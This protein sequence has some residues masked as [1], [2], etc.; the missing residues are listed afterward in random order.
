MAISLID[1][2]YNKTTKNTVREFICDTN[3]DLP[4]LPKC[5]PGSHALSVASG[6]KY[7]VNASGYWVLL[8]G[9]IIGDLLEGNGR[10]FH[11]VVPTVLVFKSPEPFAE[12][13][14][15]RINN[16]VVDPSNY[17]IEEGS[18]IVKLS[19]DYLK[20][21]DAG[22]Y[23]IVILSKNNMVTGKFTVTFTELN[24]YGI[25]PICG[26]DFNRTITFQNGNVGNAEMPASVSGIVGEEIPFPTIP[27]LSNYYF[28]G[29]YLDYACTKL[30]EETAFN[31]DLTLYAKWVS[32][33]SDQI[34]I[35]SLNADDSNSTIETGKIKTAIKEANNPDIVCLQKV[36]SNWLNH[37]ITNYTAPHSTQQS[38]NYLIYSKTDKLERIAGGVTDYCSYVVLKR[39]ADGAL[40][41]VINAYFDNSLNTDETT[42]QAQLDAMW[43]RIDG[44]WK[45]PD[46]GL[47]PI[48]ITGSIGAAPADSNVYQGLIKDSLFFDTSAITKLSLS[49]ASAATGDY[50]FASY[51]LQDSV[52]TYDLLTNTGNHYAL[53]VNI[54]TPNVCPH[55]LA[56]TEAVA[57]TCETAGNKEY[58]T[59]TIGGKVYEDENAVVET[60][61]EDC[62]IPAL[63]HTEVIDEAIPPTDT[64]TGLTE[65]KHCSICGK[66]LVE[67]EIIPAIETT[68]L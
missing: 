27:K 8:G 45:N 38:Q 32:N 19:I 49:E 12:F 63:G 57:A 10:E 37:N 35:M 9:G 66:V 6:N 7:I 28:A 39:K 17:T 51:H 21:F 47:M 54:A 67:Q 14:E 26:E 61:V 56:K 65:G 34:T 15:V 48:M 25:C 22:S 40:F 29:W 3:A 13:Q 31:E 1:I 24:E 53:I 43:E 59:C 36:G 64:D 18:T 30:F 5:E 16:K 68:E 20:T 44:I 42:R 2:K 55:I 33:I 11:H 60:T 46:R 52:E 50:V 58:Y 62:I 23:E 4:Q 41:T